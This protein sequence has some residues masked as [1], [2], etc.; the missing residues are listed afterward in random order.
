MRPA[1]EP[2]KATGCARNLVIAADE[3]I[4]V[5]SRH[6]L[7][8]VNLL[9]GL[10]A[11]LPVLAPYLESRGLHV[12]ARV[13]YLVYSMVCHQMPTRSF[14]IFGYKM[15]FCQR[16]T[17]VYGTI[18]VAGVLYGLLRPRVKPL[19]VWL[20]V[21]MALPMAVDGTGQLFGFW[22][23]TAWSRVITGALFGFA[24]VWLVY[25]YVDEACGEIRATVVEKFHKADIPLPGA[26]RRREREL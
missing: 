3:A 26:A 18:F 16:D 8:A 1:S 23:S 21:L 5:L 13:I 6:W 4:Y 19:P 12:P 10:Y 15:A 14:F 11:G 7:L 25:P 24:L 2:P 9:A 17:A 20:A 22:E